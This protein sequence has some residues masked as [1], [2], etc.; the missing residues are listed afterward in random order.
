[1]RE[2]GLQFWLLISVIGLLLVPSP[3]SYT[4]APSPVTGMSGDTNE[5]LMFVNITHDYNYSEP[6]QDS[7][8]ITADL[9]NYCTEGLIYPSTLML[10][11]TQGI[12]VTSDDVN[13]R[14]GIDGNTSYPV[15]WEVTRDST[16]A[17]GTIVT[18]E[19]HPTRDNCYSNCTEN[20]NYSYNLTIPFGL[21][22]V[23]A[24][25]GIDNITD[26]YSPSQLSFNLTAD[27]NNS[28]LGGDIHY[29]VGILNEGNGYSSSPLEGTE[30]YGQMA[31]MIFEN[32]ST[33][34]NWQISLDQNL[35]NGTYMNFSLQ[36]SCAWYTLSVQIFS[37]YMQDC[38]LTTFDNVSYTVTNGTVS[39]TTGN[40]TDN[41][42]G[43][44]ETVPPETD[45]ECP[46]PYVL[47]WDPDSDGYYYCA[48][49]SPD[50]DG[51]CPSPTESVIEDNGELECYTPDDNAPDCPE[52]SIHVSEDFSETCQPPNPEIE[53]VDP[54]GY[55]PA[56]HPYPSDPAGPG[57]NSSA[58]NWC[59]VGPYAEE[60]NECYPTYDEIPCPSGGPCDYYQ[61]PV[62]SV[63]EFGTIQFEE[64]ASVIFY[65]SWYDSLHVKHCGTIQ[66]D[67][68]DGAAPIHSQNFRDHVAAGNYDGV[69]FHRII[70]DFMIQS[71]DIQNGDG[72]GG[73][74]YSWHGYCNGYAIDQEDCLD[75][76]SYSIP[77]ETNNGIPHIPGALSMAHAGPNTG[78]SQFF[79]VDAG[80]TASWLDGMHTVFGQAIAGTIDGQVVSGVEVVDA[81]SQVDTGGYS[82]S[83][84]Y[85]D[86]MIISGEVIGED[87][88]SKPEIIVP[89][90]DPNDGGLPGFS[91]IL[92]MTALLGAA[93]V[94]I[95]RD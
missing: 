14:Y 30:V 10:N 34:V 13:W 56:S 53:I 47:T 42:T 90:N 48:E 80:V 86:V 70:D 49:P 15:V 45:L 78:G 62:D 91:A 57:D 75:N 36:P 84:P 43:G 76:T 16:V 2:R 67:L 93:F 37:S 83:S 74:A 50:E 46:S 58:T 24:C 88:E 39:N 61:P 94:R 92:A 32:T 17:E 3:T 8:N 41:G 26:D 12:N 59:C 72:T 79:I 82:D 9:F 55:C 29:P 33:P 35:A 23:N 89:T 63:C 22:D 65:L 38:D 71:G 73:Y 40:G 44:N 28:C 85:L 31:Y 21:V 6:S 18:F 69:I 20:Q 4:L 77:D 11:D 60:W 81:I 52:P 7:F 5:C 87:S 51:N 68:H 66:F 95:H 27:L 54:S 25:Y 1:M 64:A 19:M